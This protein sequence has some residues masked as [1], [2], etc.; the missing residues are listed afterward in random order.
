MISDVRGVRIREDR[1]PLYRRAGARLREQLDAGRWVTGDVLPSEA[2]LALEMGVSR[3]T[4]REALR[5]LELLGRI[6]R[7]HGRSSIVSEPPPIGSFLIR[8]ESLETLAVRQGWTCGTKEVQVTSCAATTELAELLGT[9]RGASLT[10]LERVKTRDGAPIANMQTWL[11]RN[12]ITPERLRQQ[13]RTSIIDLL[14][15][16]IKV[17]LAGALAEITASAASGDTPRRLGIPDA[18]VL[19]VLSEVFYSRA[20]LAVAYS[21]NWFVPDA[22]C[23]EVERQRF[24]RQL[25]DR[26]GALGT[27]LMARLSVIRARQ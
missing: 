17:D 6:I 20:G 25:P 2:A 15:Q 8:L 13:F 9:S 24:D 16:D 3:S 21:I 23:L 27:D 19:L 22:I 14:S 18:S 5:E 4:V 26:T 12:I 11:A 1:D 7:Q 10:Y